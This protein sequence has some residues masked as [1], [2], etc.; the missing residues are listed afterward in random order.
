MKK[1]SKAARF[2]V[3]ALSL[4]LVTVGLLGSTMARYVTEISGTATADVAAWSFKVTKDND[5]DN[6]KT[7]NLRDTVLTT[8]NYD[9]KNIA[10]GVIAPGTKGAFDIIID[11]TGSD[12]GVSYKFTIKNKDASDSLPKNISFKLTEPGE[13]AKAYTLGETKNGTISAS[14]QTKKK[15]YKVEWEWLFNDA[16]VDSGND[17][18]KLDTLDANKDFNLTITVTGEQVDPKTTTP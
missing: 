17:K 8:E 15:T 11:S 1:R 14:D 10:A 3:L 9:S 2:G 5:T 6:V 18:S 13:T 7:F 16:S 4:S 12:V